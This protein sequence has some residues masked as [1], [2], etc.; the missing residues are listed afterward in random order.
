MGSRCRSM[1][2][3]REEDREN[4][5]APAVGPLKHRSVPLRSLGRRFSLRL[6]NKSG[7]GEWRVSWASLVRHAITSPRTAALT[8]F[9]QRLASTETSFDEFD[10]RAGHKPL[11]D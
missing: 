9:G 5:S 6:S 3:W 1:G 7:R 4:V 11:V 8:N 10:Y 2:G